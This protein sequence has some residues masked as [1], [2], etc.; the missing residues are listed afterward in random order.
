MIRPLQLPIRPPGAA[1]GW[2]VPMLTTFQQVGL[3]AIRFGLTILAPFW[4]EVPHL[5]LAEI[6]LMLGALDRVCAFEPNL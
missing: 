4:H 3:T 1:A 5:S 6:G 2:H